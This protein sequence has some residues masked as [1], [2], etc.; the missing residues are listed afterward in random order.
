MKKPGLPP[1]P[2]GDSERFCKAVKETLESIT[3]ARG[4]PVKKLD[5][6]AGLSD[7][8]SKIN[9]ILDILQ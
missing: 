2:K 3:G 7:V 1:A 4:V 8:I 5:A 9:E 6:D